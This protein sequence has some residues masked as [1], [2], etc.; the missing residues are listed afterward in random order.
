MQTKHTR[1][2]SPLLLLSTL[3]LS[4]LLPGV[5]GLPGL[6]SV[7]WSEIRQPVTQ[8]S[9]WN[10]GECT[11][12][13][14][15]TFSVPDTAANV[16]IYRPGVPMR[17]GDTW[18]TWRYSLISSVVDAGAT[19]TVTLGGV[20]METTHDA[21]CEYGSETMLRYDTITIP[22]AF[23]SSVTSTLLLRELKTTIPP[24]KGLPRY[25]MSLCSRAIT[26][27]TGVFAASFGVYIQGSAA[28]GNT[29]AD[30][31][32]WSCT[33]GGSFT[34]SNYDLSYGE[35]WEIL[36]NSTG[37]NK[38]SSDATIQLVWLQEE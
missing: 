11:R 29:N 7:A 17:Y 37:T 27:D 9:L 3:L 33:S 21:I 26:R 12:I 23:A 1:H 16:A 30:S 24:H 28:A 10:R 6:G 20:R 34:V 38:D 18:G 13:N 8:L 22:G 15:Y 19:L 14:D 2:L 25:L 4:W 5:S 32:S 35:T 36:L 31:N